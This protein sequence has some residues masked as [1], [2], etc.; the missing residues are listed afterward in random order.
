MERYKEMRHGGIY[1]DSTDE[2]RWTGESKEKVAVQSGSP[3]C[4]LRDW[5]VLCGMHIKISTPFWF[6][7]RY[8]THFG[9][10]RKSNGVAFTTGEKTSLEMAQIHH[11]P[12]VSFINGE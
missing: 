4:S 2:K 11:L 6:S 5:C 12:F 9:H 1:T 7:W 8:C 3:T 10:S